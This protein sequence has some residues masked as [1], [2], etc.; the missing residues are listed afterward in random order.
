MPALPRAAVGAVVGQLVDEPSLG[1]A[2]L[3]GLSIVLPCHNEADNLVASVGAAGL[4]GRAFA[5]AH[6]IVVVDD[7]SIDGT[8]RLAREL[9]G[10]MPELRVVTHE[11]NGG[12]GAAGRS[13]IAPAAVP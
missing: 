4:A 8:G 11:R 1:V 10:E 12:D 2:M 3:A 9:A 13:A 6:E 5:M 7:G